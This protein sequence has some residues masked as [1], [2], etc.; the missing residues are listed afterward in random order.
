MVRL[1]GGGLLMRAG[2]MRHRA[3]VMRPSEALSDGGQTQSANVLLRDVPC[4][5]EHLSG[6]EAELVHAQFPEASLKVECYG[7]PNKPI[8]HT[9][10]LEVLGVGR[11]SSGQP[12]IR[13]LHISD[14]QDRDQNGILLTLF[15]GENPN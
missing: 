5:I 3:T 13:K 2:K 12:V 7:D 6:R 11:D 15:C 8:R 14:I 10:W 1:D 4:S 9:D